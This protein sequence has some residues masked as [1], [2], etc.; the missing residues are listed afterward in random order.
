MNLDCCF[1]DLEPARD[2][3]VGLAANEPTH[4]A[5]ALNTQSLALREVDFRRGSDGAGRVIVNLPSTQVGVDIRQQGQSLVVEFLRST[6][7]DNLRRKLDVADF[8]TPVQTIS[9]FQSGDK[10]RM[11]VEP[12]GAW[13]HSAYQTDNQF[14]LEVR[15]VRLDPNKLT[16][17][18]G[19]QGEKLSLNFQNIEVR[20]LL[21]VIADFTNFNVVTS[22]TVGGTVTLRKTAEEVKKSNRTIVEFTWNHTTLHAMKVDKGLTYI[23]SG[24]Q[25]GQHVQQARTLRT[26]LGDEMLV[27]LEFI[28]TLEGAMTCAGLQLVRYSSD[29]RLDRIMQIH[30]EHGVQIANPHVY[31][32]EDGKQGQVNPAV[33]ASKL[34]FDP[35][36]LLNPG[37]LR[38][39]EQREQIL[40]DAAKGS[41]SLATLP[42]C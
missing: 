40:A 39:W 37:K 19:F 36:G 31:I 21:Q 27:H 35:A 30:R 28:R 11:V 1:G 22:D 33:V 6:I 26:L 34:R 15:P 20:A 25:A 5:P 17:G 16:Q 32:V 29:E 3:L 24:F 7:P 14:V 4:F 42:R 38:G 12:R 9:T 2:D 41:V 13:E 8:G 23:Q 10:V 18:V